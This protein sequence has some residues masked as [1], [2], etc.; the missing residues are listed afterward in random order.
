MS[1]LGWKTAACV[2]THC[3]GTSP[4]RYGHAIEE[5][6]QAVV[7]S[8]GRLDVPLSR[9]S[10]AVRRNRLALH[11]A[12]SST[13]GKHPTTPALREAKAGGR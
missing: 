2:F 3:L 5:Q 10:A 8:W 6:G 7:L 11:K 4:G 12:P 1:G 9:Q 13:Q